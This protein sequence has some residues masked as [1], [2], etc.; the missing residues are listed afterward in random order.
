MITLEGIFLIISTLPFGSFRKL[1][2]LVWFSTNS[3][4]PIEQIA[5]T[6]LCILNSGK[7]LQENLNFF[8]PFLP[9]PLGDLF[10][11]ISNIVF[12]SDI[13]LIL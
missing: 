1:R 13:S 9:Y 12:F 10:I 2:S 3:S 8:L 7:I 5:N 11:N 4:T 6:R